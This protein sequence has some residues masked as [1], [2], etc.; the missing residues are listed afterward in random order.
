MSPDT[1]NM[2]QFQVSCKLLLSYLAEVLIPVQSRQVA[3]AFSL[4]WFVLPDLRQTRPR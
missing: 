2:I 4:L 3:Y 1:A